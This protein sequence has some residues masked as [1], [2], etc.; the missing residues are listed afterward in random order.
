V[1]DHPDKDQ[2]ENRFCELTKWIEKHRDLWVTRP[3]VDLPVAWEQ[4]HPAMAAQLRAL[5]SEELEE[6]ESRPQDLRGIAEPYETLAATARRLSRWDEFETV[7][8]S[9]QGPQRVP[10]RK[11]N[12]IEHFINIIQ[13]HNTS[14]V[15]TW[16]DWCS[17]KGHL[18]RELSL[19]T[20][21]TV[22]GLEN[23]LAL[24]EA[25]EKETHEA[26]ANIKFACTD[27]LT[28]DLSPWLKMDTGVVALHACGS[29]NTRLVRQ[30][31]EQKCPFAAIAP[32]CYQKI[33]G[34][35]YSPISRLGKQNNLKLHRYHLRLV[36]LDENVAGQ[37]RKD[38]RRKEQAWRQ[39]F[40]LLQR[41]GSGVEK[42][43][44]AGAV[45][46]AW[47]NQDFEYFVRMLA[48]RKDVQLPK[49][50]DPEAAEKSGWDRLKIVRSLALVRGL[51]RRLL[52]CWLI[53]DRALFLA[54][55]NYNVE[56]GTFCHSSLTPRNLMIIA[57]SNC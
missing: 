54:E 43:L 44:P 37:A 26:G 9:K 2:L 31:T 25:G 30:V 4:K 55:N 29:L 56:I 1:R 19:R 6:F 49:I 41:E 7:T 8:R 50:W 48:K 16:V 39:G 11:W 47:L 23:V 46:A 18:G 14:G 51:F 34:D 36:A 38:K 28:D 27:V 33:E 10:D 20:D 22:V 45:P 15:Q 13:S 32:C 42:Y 12:Q 35:F 57:N 24:C 3:F 17:G 5:T 53:L 52:E 40:D 21:K